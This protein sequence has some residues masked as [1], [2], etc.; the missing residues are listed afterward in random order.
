MSRPRSLARSRTSAGEAGQ[1]TRSLSK[2]STPSK[3][4]RAAA[5]SFSSRVPLSETVAIDLRITRTAPIA[6]R[7]DGGTQTPVH[8]LRIGFVPGEQAH[9]LGGLERDHG[10]A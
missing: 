5:A 8:P 9:G 1:L 7:L 4:T 10:A 6:A 3:P 2:I